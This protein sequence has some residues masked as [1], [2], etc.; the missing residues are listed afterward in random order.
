MSKII[1]ISGPVGAGKTFLG[2]MLK[3]TFGKKIIV[4]DMDD[5]RDDFIRYYYNDIRPRLIDKVEYQKYIDKFIKKHSSKHIVFVG[6]NEIPWW[7]ANHYYNMHSKYNYF[8][9]LDDETILKQKCKRLLL[10]LANSESDMKYLID[11]NEYYIKN[12][13]DAIAEECNLKIIMKR[14]NIWRKNYKKQGYRITS[15]ENIFKSVSKIL[16]T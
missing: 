10:K 1:H 13:S 6:L 7:H 11:H 15:R 4:K 9:D 8:I 12:V 5:L 16:T 3:K 2:N 14:N